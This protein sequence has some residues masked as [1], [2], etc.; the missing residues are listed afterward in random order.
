[1]EDMALQLA[2]EEPEAGP[3]HVEPLSSVVEAVT[4]RAPDRSSV[5][6]P[7]VL[8]VDGRSNNGKSTLAAR[9]C[10]LVPGSVVVHLLRS[11]PVARC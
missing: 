6:R 10:E 7:A 9:I 2:T 1:M 5:G 3:W 11:R 4:R 8:A